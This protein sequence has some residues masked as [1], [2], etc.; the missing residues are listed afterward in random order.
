VFSQDSSISISKPIPSE[1]VLK[2]VHTD[3]GKIQL[4]MNVPTVLLLMTLVLTVTPTN[5]VKIVSHLNSNMIVS[6]K[7][8]VQMDIMDLKTIMLVMFVTKLVLLV[9]V[10]NITIVIVVT[11]QDI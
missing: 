2:L 10:L 5:V 9:M 1:N 4:P 6:V 3:S 11:I 7:E 8:L